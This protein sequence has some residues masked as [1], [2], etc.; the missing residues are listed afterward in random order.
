MRIYYTD[1][2]SLDIHSE[3]LST[4][5]SNR[6]IE[7]IKKVHFE[8]DRK[9][10]VCGEPLLRYALIEEG[11]KIGKLSISKALRGKPYLPDFPEI[12]FNISHSG[13]LAVCAVGF[14]ELGI[15]TEAPRNVDIRLADKILTPREHKYYQHIDTDVLLR[16]WVFKESYMKATGRGLSLSPLD[17]SV[18]DGRF[19]SETE[20]LQH[21]F[22]SF[23][24][25]KENLISVCSFVRD[26]VTLSE[27]DS[28][29][30]IQH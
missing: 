12:H 3:S 24:T 25:V 18:I 5:L 11:I 10:S 21:G 7:K 1:I 27:I 19:I 15:D 23:F 22:F 16:Q 29:A 13:T 6:T 30:L 4:L 20:D 2:S 28:A 9:L 14:H 17:F 8:K 26:N